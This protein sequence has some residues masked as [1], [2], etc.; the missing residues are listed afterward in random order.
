MI[1]NIS[2]KLFM[3]ANLMGEEEGRY[4]IPMHTQKRKKKR[5]KRDYCSIMASSI[6]SLYQIIILF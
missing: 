2:N 5:K 1:I 6:T 4:N 3:Q